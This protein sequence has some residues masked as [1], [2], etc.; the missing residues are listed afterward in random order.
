MING[1]GLFVLLLI[2]GLLIMIYSLMKVSSD[3]SEKEEADEWEREHSKDRDG[4]GV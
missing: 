2:L 4:S 3:C 1:W